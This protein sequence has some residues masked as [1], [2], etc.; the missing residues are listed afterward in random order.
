MLGARHGNTLAFDLNA[1]NF[2]CQ[3]YSAVPSPLSG[4]RD[5][6]RF[7][8]PSLRS[9]CSENDGSKLLRMATKDSEPRS[10]W[11]WRA[12]EM[13]FSVGKRRTR[14]AGLH[15]AGH[16]GEVAPPERVS[17]A[18]LCCKLTCCQCEHP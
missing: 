7:R 2:Q 8:V 12:L 5:K 16:L 3:W 14:L 10:G 6:Q 4:S 17:M 1:G 18:A 9:V 13:R 11:Q 15:L